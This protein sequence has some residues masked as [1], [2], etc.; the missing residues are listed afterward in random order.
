MSSWTNAIRE[1]LADPTVSTALDAVHTL[2][3]RY[4][5][6]LSYVPEHQQPKMHDRVTD[7]TA[8]VAANPR[9]SATAS[10]AG[11]TVHWFDGWWVLI[12]TIYK[13]PNHAGSADPQ[14][15]L[16]LHH[17]SEELVVY[18]PA[19]ARLAPIPFT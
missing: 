5:T 6:G 11:L 9:G 2:R 7:L 14:S 18:G 10:A 8:W 4:P 17:R 3:R 12:G 13:D 16:V 19:V 15:P 1:A